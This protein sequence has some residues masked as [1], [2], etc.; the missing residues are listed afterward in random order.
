MFLL[1]LKSG[2]RER[3]KWREKRCEML[4][5]ER[6]RETRNESDKLGER[7]KSVERER[8]KRRKENI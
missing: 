1:L 3:L 2:E 6:G 8:K 4:M 7:K 5:L